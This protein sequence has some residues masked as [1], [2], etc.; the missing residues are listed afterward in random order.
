MSRERGWT[1]ALATVGV[2]VVLDQLTKA[3]VRTD[4]APQ[5][6]INVFFLLDV[7]NVK[8]TGVAFGALSGSGALV[9]VAVLIAMAGL[10]LY[11]AGH[12]TDSG[13][14]LPVGMVFGGAL[15]NLADRVRIDGVT[16]F[17]DPVLWPA[18]NVADMCI[19]LGVL[20]VLYLAESKR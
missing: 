13:L 2:V 3:W 8:N 9:F 7:T 6:K 4:V 14:W 17:I 15:G 1:L 10:L 5:E 20:G 16:D 18:F 19:V 11:F 12:V